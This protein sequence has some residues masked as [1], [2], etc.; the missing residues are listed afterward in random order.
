MLIRSVTPCAL[1]FL[2]VLSLRATPA[3]AQTIGFETRPGGAATE[4]RQEISTQYAAYGVRF[5]TD[6]AELGVEGDLV[7]A[8]STPV[9]QASGVPD[10]SIEPLAPN[11]VRQ[12][13]DLGLALARPARTR[14][15]VVDIVGRR[16][17][18]LLTGDLAAG[19]H[20]V[21][22]DGTMPITARRS[23]PGRGPAGC[24]TRDTWDR[25]PAD[26]GG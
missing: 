20:H 5:L 13:A 8:Y 12:Q 11:P 15:T 19:R 10:L 6:G 22:G 2:F 7:I 3:R 4:D 24:P 26:P 25:P 23:P 16:V 21:A 17:A 14:V 1:I 18:G 9:T